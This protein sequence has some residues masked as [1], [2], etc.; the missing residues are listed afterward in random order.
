MDGLIM[1]AE[2]D[3]QGW[4]VDWACTECGREVTTAATWT[5]KPVCCDWEMI[6]LFGTVRPGPEAKAPGADDHSRATARRP[7][8]AA[9]ASRR[10]R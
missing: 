9:E 8:A 5:E 6:D 4:I 3:L 10:T 7:R 1:S 2:Q